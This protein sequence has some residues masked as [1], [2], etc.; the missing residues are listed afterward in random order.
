MSDLWV[1]EKFD[2]VYIG[3]EYYEKSGTLMSWIYCKMADGSFKRFDEG[4]VSLALEKNPKV[5]ITCRRPTE[6]E[7]EYFEKQLSNISEKWGKPSDAG[8]FILP[9]SEDTDIAIRELIGDG[10]AYFIGTD[11]L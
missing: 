10:R 3:K 11:K 8:F 9:E 2:L 7:R 1:G 4:Y 5:T 6:K